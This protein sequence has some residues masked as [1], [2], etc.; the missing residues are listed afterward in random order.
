MINLSSSG[1]LHSVDLVMV[2]AVLKEYYSV[3]I[4]MVQKYK[5]NYESNQQDATI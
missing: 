3:F 5:N 2:K 4:F 1:M